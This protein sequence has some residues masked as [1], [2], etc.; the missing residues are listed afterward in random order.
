MRSATTNIESAD[1][2][3]AQPQV[4]GSREEIVDRIGR[5]GR[6]SVQCDLERAVG[7]LLEEEERSGL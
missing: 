1:R 4:R 5:V 7:V 6:D 3:S 2:Y